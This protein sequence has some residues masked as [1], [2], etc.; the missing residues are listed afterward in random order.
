MVKRLRVYLSW[1]YLDLKEY[2]DA[3]FDALEKDGLDVARMEAYTAADERPLD[4]C[5]RDVSQQPRARCR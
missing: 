3:A 2:R 4:L 1:T 5:L